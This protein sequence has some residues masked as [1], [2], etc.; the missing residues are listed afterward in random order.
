MTLNDS[1]LA[2]PPFDR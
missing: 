1:S 2:M